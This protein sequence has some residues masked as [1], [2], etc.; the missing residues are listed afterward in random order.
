MIGLESVTDLLGCGEGL[1]FK[2]QNDRDAAMKDFHDGSMAEEDYFSDDD[3]PTVGFPPKLSDYRDAN[4]A[5]HPGITVDKA[6]TDIFGQYKNEYSFISGMIYKLPAL[7]EDVSP[8]DEGGGA[9][10]DEQ[11]DK[12][13]NLLLGPESKVYRLFQDA[14]SLPYQK[15]CQFMATFYFICRFNQNW[16]ELWKDEDINTDRFME[17]K[18]F[19]RVL[20]RIDDYGKNEMFSRRF[21]EE[22][23]DAVN[24]VMVKHFVPKKAGSSLSKLTLTY[25]DDK[26]HFSYGAMRDI[27]IGEDS[28]LQR[29]RHIRDNK[30]GVTNHVLAYAATDITIVSK[31]QHVDHESMLDV[32]LD[33][34]KTLFNSKFEK[35][36]NLSGKATLAIDR[37]YTRVAILAWWLATGGDVIGTLMRGQGWCPFTFGQE[38][39]KKSSIKKE[40]DAE[41]ENIPVDGFQAVY[42]KSATYKF[43]KSGEKT[44]TLTCMAYRSHSSAVAMHVT[45]RQH[46]IQWDMVLADA[47][48]TS[49]Y[50][51][52]YED[53]IDECGCY[54]DAFA[55]VGGDDWEEH[56]DESE[57]D[58][59]V[60]TRSHPKILTD[61]GVVPMTW[62][63]LCAAWWNC[64]PFSL[65][66]S[67][68]DKLI[69]AAA[70]YIT[71]DHP[72][73]RQFEQ[74]LAYTG[75]L[76]LLPEVDNNNGDSGES[77]SVNVNNNEP[78]NDEPSS[79]GDDGSVS[80]SS[81][82]I[83]R[84]TEPH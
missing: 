15:F 75:Q 43:S 64:R 16:K 74:I 47:T 56:C 60:D 57:D 13:A 23:E 79:S 19:Y 81:D 83:Y 35:K 49:R 33:T 36:P 73:R 10:H 82:F 55:L 69:I 26:I 76:G 50:Q 17:P 78:M 77:D 9:S 84:V 34:M 42:Q 11:I 12:V 80:I 45:S 54:M 53:G 5:T 7:R 4:F 21:W 14:L 29:T 8:E 20:H 37:G 59:E 2:S 71:P 3:S 63:Q 30:K 24:S 40:G 62:T 6:R 32:F 70:P 46:G 61:Q 41:P 18:L 65:T 51:E 67:A 38:K 68:V 22:L 39:K 28:N 1:A 25:D 31:L 52:Y 58:E 44:R 48:T 66:S 72:M 27:P